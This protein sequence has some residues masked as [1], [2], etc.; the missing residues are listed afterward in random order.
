MSYFNYHA[1]CKKLI[2]SKHFLGATI[3][4]T[5]KHISP[6]LV[7]YF[8]NHKPMPIREYRWSEYFDLLKKLNV[9]THN[10]LE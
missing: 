4:P 2:Q 9:K 10:T 7:F 8:D 3:L 6:A 5:Y 1:Q